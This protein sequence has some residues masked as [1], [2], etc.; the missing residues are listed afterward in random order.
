M[1]DGCILVKEMELLLKDWQFVS[2]DATGRSGGLLLGWR[3]CNFLLLNAW[4]MTSGICVVLHSIEL[5]LDLYFINI[6]GPY[7][8]REVFWNNLSNMDCFKCPYLVFGGDLISPW[9]FLKFGGLKHVWM[10]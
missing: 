10:H 2:V 6:Y 3:T 7:M 4:A 8:D 5:Q 1:F 9:I